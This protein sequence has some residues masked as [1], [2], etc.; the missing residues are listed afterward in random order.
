MT[1]LHD[2]H[3]EPRPDAELF[4]EFANT[5]HVHDGVPDDRVVDADALRAWLADRTLLGAD[6]SLGSVERA[7]PDF[8]DL[9]GL[10]HDVT[11]RLV[12]DGRPS[13]RQVQRLNRVLR[14]GFHYHRLEPDHEGARFT[15]RQVG[16]HLDQARSA[17]AGSLAH[18]LADH[19]VGRLRIC[20]NDDCRWRFVDRSPAGRR[21]WCDM[22][23]C[24]NRAK[25]A[26]HRERARAAQG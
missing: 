24:G 17:I 6:A 16:D 25:V 23:T 11:Q 9:R 26:A 2:T 15:I 10:I 12:E 3:P 13:A 18:Y 7:L 5:L 22:R 19:D 8:R 1:D 4:I 21:R 20:A 14:D